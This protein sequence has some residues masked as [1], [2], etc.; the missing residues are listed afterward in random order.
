M[1]LKIKTMSLL[2][3]FTVDKQNIPNIIFQI[4]KHVAL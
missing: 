4:F 1:R 3:L 2:S